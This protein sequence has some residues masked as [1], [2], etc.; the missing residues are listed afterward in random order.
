VAGGGLGGLCLAQGLL[1]AGVDVTVYERDAHLAARRQGY[2]LHVDA[3]AGRALEQC[4]PSESLAVFQATCGDASRRL[5]VMSERLRVLSEQSSADSAADPYA[6]ATLST[7]VN[8]QTMR[9]VL[10]AGLDSRLVFG[11]ELVR[12]D[13]GQDGVRLH[14]ADG[15][16]AE[17]D[18]LVGADGVNSAV[19]RQYLPAAE[20][21]DTGKRCIYG[22]TP[23][24]AD[25]MDRL[26]S[27]LQAGFTAVIGGGIGLATGLVRFRQRPEQA[28]FGLTPAGDYLMWALAADRKRFGVP[29]EHLTAMAPAELHA[30]SAKLIRTWHPDLR[31]LLAEAAIDETFLV[32]IRTSRPVPPWPTSR[33]TVLGDAIHAMSPARGSGANTALQD[34]ALLCRTLTGATGNGTAA[35]RAAGN[36]ANRAAGNGATDN[37]SVG[38]VEDL[39]HAIGDYERQMRDYGYAAV[40]ASIQAETETGMRNHRF[41]FWLYRRITGTPA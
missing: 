36:A 30:L 41:M 13:A 21:V 34:A 8:R 19:R 33:V 4:L 22:K 27:A 39:L 23:L 25:V 24:R 3:R 32:R 20:A 10:A 6:P 26:P 35:N 31:A 9:E 7:S 28:G 1:K 16:Q 38:A 14:F 17:A 12:Y 37:E 2:R 29:D 11:S 40:A 5:T 15:R 18:L